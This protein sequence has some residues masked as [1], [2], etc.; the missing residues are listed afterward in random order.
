MRIDGRRVSP[1]HSR[2]SGNAVQDVLYL[3]D[4][5]ADQG[6]FG[7]VPDCHRRIESW[8]A[9]L[10]AGIDP[11]T[12]DLY[13]LGRECIAGHAGDLIIWHHALPHGSSPNR[14]KRPRIVQYISLQPSLRERDAVWK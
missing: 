4:V 14:A 1:A 9:S 8:L 12:A 7:C 10:P 2:N 5:A 6:A 3:V 13:A 11:R